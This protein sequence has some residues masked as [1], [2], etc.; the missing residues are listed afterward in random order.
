MI[1]STTANIARSSRRPRKRNND[2][3]TAWASSVLC[4]SLVAQSWHGPRGDDLATE[5]RKATSA[6][7]A[8]HSGRVDHDVAHRSEQM[9]HG[10]T[11][12]GEGA[13]NAELG[14]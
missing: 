10:A 7:E 8:A 14:T 3:A 9:A 11:T 6:T 2:G 4:C 1:S 12:S 13:Q 5:S